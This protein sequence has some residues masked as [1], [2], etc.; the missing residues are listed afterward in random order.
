MTKTSDYV[1]RAVVSALAVIALV[2][3]VRAPHLIDAV[4]AGL[5]IIALLP[6]LPSIIKS[7]EVTGVGRLELH[8]L[9]I[10]ERERTYL[11]LRQQLEP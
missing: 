1:L 11:R 9:S 2:V 5:I 6:W 7:I 10:T 8:Y 3:H 4:G